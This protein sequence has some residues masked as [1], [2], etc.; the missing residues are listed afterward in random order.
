MGH[1][2]YFWVNF[3][4]KKLLN[5]TK[6][7]INTKQLSNYQPLLSN[8]TNF[9]ERGPLLQGRALTGCEYLKELSY[10]QGLLDA[11]NQRDFGGFI[12]IFTAILKISKPRRRV[13]GKIRVVL[14]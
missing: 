10:P 13:F 7:K 5:N 4:N 11:G 9:F 12:R 14:A 1:G 2:S 3:Y 6:N 8:N